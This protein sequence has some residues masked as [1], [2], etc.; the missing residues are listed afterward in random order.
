[1]IA[2]RRTVDC[3]AYV[4]L[5][6]GVLAAVT[7][8]AMVAWSPLRAAFAVRPGA[9]LGFGFHGVPA[10]WDQA[11]TLFSENVASAPCVAMLALAMWVRVS[12]TIPRERWRRIYVA[13]CDL[14]ALVPLLLNAAFLGAAI[15]V[16]GWR[17]LSVIWLHGP[18][19]VAGFALVGSVYLQSRRSQGTPRSTAITVASAVAFLATAAVLETFTG[20]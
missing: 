2:T 14:G 1:M 7:A 20:H 16:Y 9:G 13:V 6:Y 11:A 5:L 18:V 10:T 8:G 4:A 17:V 19:E 12:Q 15:G 3:A